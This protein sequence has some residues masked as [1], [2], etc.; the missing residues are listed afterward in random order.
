MELSKR[1]IS[2]LGDAEQSWVVLPEGL[3]K[4]EGRKEEASQR[5]LKG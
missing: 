3:G 2:I 4:A 5:G 1:Q